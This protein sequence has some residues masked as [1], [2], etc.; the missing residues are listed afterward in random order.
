MLRYVVAGV[1]LVAQPLTAQSETQHAPS[2]ERTT[3]ASR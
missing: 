2:F 1:V 3:C